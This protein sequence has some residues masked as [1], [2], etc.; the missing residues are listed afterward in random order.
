M[1]ESDAYGRRL[2]ELW[3][4]LTREGSVKPA[5]AAVTQFPDDT[6]VTGI[7]ADSRRVRP[8]CLFVAVHGSR[9]DGHRYIDDA[10]NRGASAIIAEDAP[11]PGQASSVPVLLVD[12]SR[13]ALAQLAA[14]WH[15][16][17]AR[18]LSLVGITGTF[19][20]TSVLAMLEAILRRDGAGIGVIGSNA[21]GIRVLHT[22]H[23]RSELTT[24]D[25]ISL[26]AALARFADAGVEWAAMEVTSQALKQQRVHGLSFRVGVFT[27]LRPLEHMETHGTF[28]RYVAVKGRFFEHLE[29]HA[30]LVYTAG[31]RIV[32]ELARRCDV[33]PIGC[34]RGGPVA[35]R[36]THRSLDA[37]RTR[38]VVDVRR[39][40]PS[41]AG[42]PR[43]PVSLPI[44][45]PAVG[46]TH[47]INAGIA[48]TTALILGA[49]PE[50]VTRAL[51]EFPPPFRRMQLVHRDGFTV[52][53]DTAAH[54]DAVSAVLELIEDMPHRRFHVVV[55]VRGRRGA[56]LNRRY[57]ESLAI[58]SQR[59]PIASVI[60]TTSEDV[61]AE[62]DR[63]E[64]E[65]L[66][67]FMEPLAES[68]L[69]HEVHRTLDSAIQAACDRVGYDDLLLL[70]GAQGMDQG[71]RR[72]LARL[73][74]NR[75]AGHGARD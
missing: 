12:D 3:A 67:A 70:M 17:P 11:P 30:P 50:A 25:P 65:E 40:L 73:A 66:E 10:V 51:S 23:R 31:E 71:A 69:E 60:V 6:R 1:H 72:A 20:K 36:V 29:R 42:P 46:R 49:S 56:E 41:A 61:A 58:W 39:P 35:V 38:L 74:E 27:N 4:A 53:D 57:A 33:V 9:D 68:G 44:V 47:A 18:R 62:K 5:T 21:V 2:Q 54:P 19:G 34:G 37:M 64:P 59:V 16:Y 75:R 22:F 32:R 48:A 7:T 13:R 55:A 15:G 26:H 28:R 43:P 24:P 14:A 45:L 8:G 63:V 52:L